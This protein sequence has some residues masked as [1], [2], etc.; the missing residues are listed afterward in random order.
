MIKHMHFF[1]D[2][3]TAGD[4]ILDDEF[5]PWKKDCRTSQEYFLRRNE[6]F[7]DSHFFAEYVGASKKYAYPALLETNGIRVYNHAINGNSLQTVVVQLT[8]LIL[9]KAE[10]DTVCIQI[11]N[12][13]RQAWIAENGDIRSISMNISTHKSNKLLQRFVES[14]IMIF[15]DAHYAVLDITSL[16]LIDSFCKQNGIEIFLTDFGDLAFRFNHSE[17]FVH[18]LSKVTRSSLNIINFADIDI[19]DSHRLLGHHFDKAGHAIIARIIKEHI[20]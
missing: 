11:P 3:F 9:E 4:E 18:N 14:S 13:I 19:L 15:D 2:S 20:L 12:F 10:I 1:G 5:F 17:N 16:F 7:L 8:K 6:Y